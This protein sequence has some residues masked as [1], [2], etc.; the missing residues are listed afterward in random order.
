[1]PGTDVF[2]PAEIEA[3]LRELERLLVDPNNAVR[4]L[5][6]HDAV[7][8][9]GGPP[10]RGHEELLARFV[11]PLY[12]AVITPES[13][14]GDGRLASVF[15]QFT[16][17]IPDPAAGRIDVTCHFMLVLR[18]EDDGVWRVARECLVQDDAPAA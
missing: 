18:K 7:L 9:N 15:G 6:S 17:A 14:L 2:D 11:L 8:M 3:T 10:V 4:V 13:I 16:C 12:D 5:Y 1:M